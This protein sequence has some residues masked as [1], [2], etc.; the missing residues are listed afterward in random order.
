MF[1]NIVFKRS[2]KMFLYYFAILSFFLIVDNIAFLKYCC[3]VFNQYSG[4][5]GAKV[6]NQGETIKNFL[7]LRR[8]NHRLHLYPKA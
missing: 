7:F 1:I 3:N 4:V 2:A 5:V 6:N 8:S